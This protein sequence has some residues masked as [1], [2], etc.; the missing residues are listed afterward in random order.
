MLAQWYRVRLLIRGSQVRIRL[1]TRFEN[2]DFVRNLFFPLLK[3]CES[4]EESCPYVK[5][6][7]PLSSLN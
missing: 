7:D 6:S 1:V 5:N 3:N 4:E 2:L